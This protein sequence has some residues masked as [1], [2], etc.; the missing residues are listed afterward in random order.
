[1]IPED[2]LREIGGSFVRIDF[3]EAAA[4]ALTRGA[5]D[6]PAARFN[7]QGEDAL[8]LSPDAETAW[9]GI[10]ST[11]AAVGRQRVVLRL[12]VGR[13]RV[14]DLRH[15][16]AAAIYAEACQPWR[17]ALADGREPASWKAADAVR[18]AGLDGLIDP[19]RQTPGRWA[20]TLFRW[21][22]PDAPRV[23]QAG[24]PE[25]FRPF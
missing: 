24:R 3:A 1:M 10:R 16:S 6:R 15:P 14:L 5:P 21:N 8:Y 23:R 18:R 12:R 11:A 2:A 4:R 13:A 17:S 19:S 25:P 7:R 20:L 22:A 9:L